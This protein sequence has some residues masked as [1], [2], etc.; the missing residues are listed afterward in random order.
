M[1]RFKWPTPPDEYFSKHLKMRDA[2]DLPERIARCRFMWEQ[3]GPP[4]GMLLIGG[5]PAMFA[6]RELQ[7]S[8]L[9]G[10]FVATV[11]LA[12]SFV[13]H[14]LGAAYSMAGAEAVVRQGFKALVE[15]AHSDGRVPKELAEK[16]HTLRKMRNPY[17]HYSNYMERL[18]EDFGGCQGPSTRRPRARRCPSSD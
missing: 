10:N 17:T 11:L 12:Q 2:S 3:F 18:R 5:I 13:E 1:I 15:A 14:S 16:L 8:F 4:S 9:D 6:I 7:R